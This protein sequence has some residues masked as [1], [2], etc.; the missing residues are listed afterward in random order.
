MKNASRAG[1]LAYY[2]GRAA[3]TQVAARYTASGHHLCEERWR[4]R[5]GEIDLVMRMNDALVFVEVKRAKTHH[6][7]AERI[8]Q[9]QT[10]RLFASASEYLAQEPSGQST[11]CRFDVALVDA[12]GR[13][14]VIENALQHYT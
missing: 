7:A 14:E 12:M 8:T 11:N 4:G 13:I 5:G 1:Q 10:A 6:I 9:R 2:S 3:E